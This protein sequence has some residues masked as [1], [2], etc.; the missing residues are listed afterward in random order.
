[1]K[2]KKMSDLFKIAK[3]RE[4]VAVFSHANGFWINANGYSDWYG[5]IDEC[6]YADEEATYITWDAEN[7][8]VIEIGDDEE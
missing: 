8:L 3:V 4:A 7:K 2:T 6:P 1:M 5:S